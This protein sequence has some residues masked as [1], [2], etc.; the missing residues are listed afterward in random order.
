MRLVAGGFLVVVMFAGVAGCGRPVVGPADSSP[1]PSPSPSPS[2]SGSGAPGAVT[3]H[4]TGGFAGVDH[5]LEVAPD[6]AWTY[7][8]DGRR[9]SGRL[10]SSQVDTLRALSSDERLPAEAKHQDKRNCQDGFTYDV[11]V[12]SFSITAVECGQFEERPALTE[13]VEFL[14]DTTP[15]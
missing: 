4:R 10:T 7:T 8:G 13:L 14:R 5:R 2:S 11:T 12:G 9:E 6:G 1:S 15:L 3:L